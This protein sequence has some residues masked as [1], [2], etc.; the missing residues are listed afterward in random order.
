MEAKSRSDVN[1]VMVVLIVLA[2]RTSSSS[3]THS[4]SVTVPWSE[5]GRETVQERVTL[6]PCTGVSPTLEVKVT[7]VLGAAQGYNERTHAH[8]HTLELQI[9][10][11]TA[12]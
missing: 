3:C 5:A 12:V 9:N 6:L 2:E 10:H 4:M 7:L 8:T 1:D 11:G